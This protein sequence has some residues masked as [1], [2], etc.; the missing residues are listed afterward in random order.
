MNK[1]FKKEV[2]EINFEGKNINDILET[3]VD[4]A[5][6]FFTEHEQQKIVNKLNL[7]LVKFYVKKQ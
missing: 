3:T 5:M 1:R 7:D 4:E 6:L 2:L